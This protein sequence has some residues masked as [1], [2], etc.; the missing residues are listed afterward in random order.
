MESIITVEEMQQELKNTL[1]VA[2]NNLVQSSSIAFIQANTVE[3]TLSEMK[4]DHIIPVF[5][6]DNEPLISHAELI[7]MVGWVASDAFPNETILHPNI[8]VSHPIKGRVPEARNKPAK[9]LLEWE[10]TLYYERMAFAIEVP[11]ISEDVDGNRLSLTL[12]GVKAYNLDN[13]NAK[14]GTDE[15]FKLFI[16]FQNRVCTNLCVST[17]GTL[18]DLKVRSKEQLEG[19]IRGMIQSYRQEH[20]LRSMQD[21]S[22]YSLTEQQFALLMGRCRMYQHLPTGVKRDIPQLLFHD[23]QLG[24]VCKDYYR[25][26]SF[27]R[28]DAGNINLW[29]LYNLFTGANKGSY[30]DAFLERG[31]NAFSFALSIKE[32]LEQSAYNWYLS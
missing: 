4:R 31:T 7:E 22:R 18:L 2:V 10:K 25:D 27:C 11:T 12:G 3:C 5:L 14:R 6:K 19:A 17:D 30:I 1:S 16:G 15:H 29:R 20:H 28:D 9:E 26:N 24:T 13:L 32:G 21:M 23:T 8:R